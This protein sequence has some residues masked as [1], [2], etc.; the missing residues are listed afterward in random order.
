MNSAPEQDELVE[1]AE[2]SNLSVADVQKRQSHPVRIGV[3]VILTI[4]ALTLPYGLGRHLALEKTSS[5]IRLVSAYDPSS[6]ALLSWAITTLTFMAT[7]MLLADSKRTLWGIITL[8][9]FSLQQFLCGIGLVK[10]GFW[11]ATAVV[12]GRAAGYANALNIGVF[13]SGVGLALFLIIYLIL[14][15]AVKKTSSLNILT[16][17]WMALLF[18]FLVEVLVL[19]ICYLGGIVSMVVY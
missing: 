12:Y 7:G 14:L 3:F 13:A 18:L 19:L 15:L 5:L 9:A 1:S 16:R 8:L 4:L 10:T 11:H 2:K 17:S 6:G